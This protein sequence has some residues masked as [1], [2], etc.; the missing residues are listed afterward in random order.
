MV[1]AIN[2]TLKDEMAHDPRIVVF[3]QDVADAS[4]ES[5]LPLVAGKGGVF[6]ATHGLQR[7]FGSD[8]VFNSPLAEANIVGRAVG[9]GAARPEAGRRDSVLRLHLAGVHADSRRALD[10]A[11]S[12]G[13]SL[14][15]PGGDSRADR[16]LSA[17][18]RAVSQ[19]VGRLDLRAHARHQNRAALERPG[20]GRPAAHGDS[21]RRP[22][23]LLRAQASLSPDLQQGAVSRRGLHGA[24][25]QG[26]R[27]SRWQ[28]RRHLHVGRARPAFA[29]GGPAGGT[30]GHQAWP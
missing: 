30:A 25:R 9:H 16:R 13:Q 18:R 22:G 20:R 11:L 15:V 17:R 28:R 10:D 29:A 23:A 21:M 8:R 2:A 12:L 5:A 27:G 7:A 14:V 6:K 19:P 3:G 1:A 4:H 24:A 26:I